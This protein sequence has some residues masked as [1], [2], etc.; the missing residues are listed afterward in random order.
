VGIQEE[1]YMFLVD[2][3]H[4]VNGTVALSLKLEALRGRKK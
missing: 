3:I 2:N 4:K 1:N